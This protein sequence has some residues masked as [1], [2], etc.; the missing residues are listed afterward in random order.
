MRSYLKHTSPGQYRRGVIRW[1]ED[2]FVDPK[3][4]DKDLAQLEEDHIEALNKVGLNQNDF[5]RIIIES[6]RAI[7]RPVP[8][9]IG[10]GKII[11][12]IGIQ[13]KIKLINDEKLLIR[14]CIRTSPILRSMFMGETMPGELSLYSIN[15]EAR[16]IEYT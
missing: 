6:F 11:H 10:L 14:E 4:Q 7:N 2:Y 12:R 3:N 9:S 5:K 15:T 16:T 8:I 13:T 1:L